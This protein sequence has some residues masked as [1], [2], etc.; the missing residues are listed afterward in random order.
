[1]KK[2]RVKILFAGLGSANFTVEAEDKEKAL[3]RVSYILGSAFARGY[4]VKEVR[5]G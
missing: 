4:S 2:F 1:M 3:A 5:E